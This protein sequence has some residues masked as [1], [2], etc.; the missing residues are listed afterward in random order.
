MSG[1]YRAGM[2][3]TAHRH[4]HERDDRPRRSGGV[5]WAWVVLVFMLMVFCLGVLG[6]VVALAYSPLVQGLFG[7]A[8]S[9]PPAPRD[10]IDDVPAPDNT[11][12]QTP[13]AFERRAERLVGES[14]EIDPDR[15]GEQEGAPPP[16]RGLDAPLEEPR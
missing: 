13:D 1:W 11:I 7:P 5:T 10:Q 2:A 16:I 9:E 3:G 4:H 14:G 12:S 6:G 8:E 15:V